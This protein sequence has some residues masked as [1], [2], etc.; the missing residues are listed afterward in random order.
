[1]LIS[2]SK[3]P[4]FAWGGEE[5]RFANPLK[6]GSVNNILLPTMKLA[7]LT[8]KMG[9]PLHVHNSGVIIPFYY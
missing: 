6:C 9:P 8:M 4:L 3:T 5:T 7:K 2:F 1:M